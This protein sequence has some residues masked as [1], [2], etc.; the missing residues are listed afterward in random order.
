LTDKDDEETIQGTLKGVDGCP[1]CAADGLEVHK[2]ITFNRIRK[3]VASMVLL[4]HSPYF[5]TGTVLRLPFTK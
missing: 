3:T 2:L 4:S 5:T 1:S